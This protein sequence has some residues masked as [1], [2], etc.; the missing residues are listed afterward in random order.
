[1]I[2]CCVRYSLELRLKNGEKKKLSELQMTAM[3]HSKKNKSNI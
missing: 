3:S 1:M 2:E